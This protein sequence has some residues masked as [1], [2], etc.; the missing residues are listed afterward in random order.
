M[1]ETL[2]QLSR[3]A[4]FHHA[5]R[6]GDTALC[7]KLIRR[8]IDVQHDN[9]RGIIE[10]CTNGHLNI[11]ICLT[12]IK[13]T[14]R[15]QQPTMYKII[16]FDAIMN[17]FEI[18]CKDGHLYIVQYLLIL[19]FNRSYDISSHIFCYCI[20]DG[21]LNACINGHY[22]IVRAIT[23]SD[24][25]INHKMIDINSHNN[26]TLYFEEACRNGHLEIVKF[27]V[28]LYKIAD[29]DMIDMY[30]DTTEPSLECYPLIKTCQNGYINIIKYI[31]NLYK[32]TDYKMLNINAAC[33]A[34]FKFACTSHY[35]DIAQYLVELTIK[36]SAYYKPIN[37]YSYDSDVDACLSDVLESPYTVNKIPTL[38]YM[39]NIGYIF[40]Q[41]LQNPNVVYF[42]KI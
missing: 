41:A 37:F 24:N 7:I 33:D 30:T 3:F 25:I 31:I 12:T 34:S 11:I 27:L 35:I 1:A 20:E 32:T 42:D 6:I 21:L 14:T 13:C 38:K 19:M 9:N 29:Y 39:E 23:L 5:C 22:D 16:N 26:S 18:A 28:S 36:Y 8:G 2:T 15:N 4:L 40:H 10:A 17:C